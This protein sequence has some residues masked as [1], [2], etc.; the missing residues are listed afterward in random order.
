MDLNAWLAAAIALVA[1]LYLGYNLRHRLRSSAG[2][3]GELA[4]QLDGRF[5]IVQFFAPL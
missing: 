5:T 3:Y 1:L 4:L 2:S